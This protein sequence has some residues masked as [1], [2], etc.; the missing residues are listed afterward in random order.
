MERD[1]AD[2]ITLRNFKY[3][4]YPGLSKE[5]LNVFTR[6]LMRWGQRQT[7]ERKENNVTVEARGEKVRWYGAINQGMRKA[8][9]SWQ[10]NGSP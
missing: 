10:R 7:I 3:G 5:A 1:G 2:V 9:K 6:I 4:H 8:S